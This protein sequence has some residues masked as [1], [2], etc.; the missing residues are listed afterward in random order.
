MS[1]VATSKTSTSGSA[2]VLV[3][4]GAGAEVEGVE[5]VER[6]AVD[7]GWL[8]VDP[9]AA[10]VMAKA[11]TMTGYR[12]NLIVGSAPRCERDGRLTARWV[13]PMVP[14]GRGAT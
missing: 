5:G 9:H 2:D 14:A 3:G 10:R 6:D 13:Q 1:P 11:A 12:R 7:V 4:V 8:E